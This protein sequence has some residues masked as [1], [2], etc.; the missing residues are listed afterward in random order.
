MTTA[1]T[2]QGDTWDILAFRLLGSEVFVDKLLQINPTLRDVAVFSAGQT[3]NV[4]DLPAQTDENLP[5]WRRTSGTNAGTLQ[6]AGNDGANEAA[7]REMQEAVEGLKGWISAGIQDEVKE[8]FAT[9]LVRSTGTVSQRS[10][11]DRFADVINVRDFGAK[12][13]GK[14]DDTDAIQAAFD[15]HVGGAAGGRIVFPRGTYV[16][17]DS[18]TLRNRNR[19]RTLGDDV[20]STQWAQ[21][22]LC[23]S[24][25]AWHG[26]DDASPVLIAMV[27][28]CTIMNGQ[29]LGAPKNRA[30]DTHRAEV[31]LKMLNGEAANEVCFA[32]RIHNMQLNGYT[33]AG[34]QIGDVDHMGSYG[35]QVSDCYITA[36]YSTFSAELFDTAKSATQPG[37]SGPDWESNGPAGIELWGA[38]C[39]FVNVTTQ[40]NKRHVWLHTSGHQFTNCHFCSTALINHNDASQIAS[41]ADYIAYAAEHEINYANSAGMPETAGIWY[42]LKDLINDPPLYDKTTKWYQ[43]TFIGCYFDNVK[44]IVYNDVSHSIQTQLNGCFYF[45]ASSVVPANPADPRTY[46]LGGPADTGSVVHVTNFSIQPGTKTRFLSGIEPSVNYS[47]YCRE[48]YVRNTYANNQISIPWLAQYK[49]PSGRAVQLGRVSE[50]AAGTA[51]CLGGV[52]VRDLGNAVFT[53]KITSQNYT[54]FEA[55]IR[56]RSSNPDKFDVDLKPGFSTQAFP[57]VTLHEPIDV[58]V[59]GTALK[60][61]PIC[62]WND[63]SSAITREVSATLECVNNRCGLYLMSLSVRSSLADLETRGVVIKTDLR[64]DANTPSG[65]ARLVTLRAVGG[66]WETLQLRANCD[67]ASPETNLASF[68]ST[69]SYPVRCEAGADSDAPFSGYG[70]LEVYALPSY[71]YVSSN[72]VVIQKL[73]SADVA[74]HPLPVTYIRTICGSNQSIVG[75]WREVAMVAAGS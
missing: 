27:N 68:L 48:D 34:L 60:F 3:I 55:D 56:Y 69:G 63:G 15:E 46:L 41:L 12:G 54:S 37:Y 62:L 16:V 10:L 14:T 38:D 21:L 65:S 17:T 59:R 29:I 4:P 7:R 53:L 42:S 13:D 5:L 70:L 20:Y 57:K 39:K 6:A 52:L 74:T 47:Y 75:E 72:P 35:T 22:D 51:Y 11:N 66:L 32:A 58:D 45:N 23:G 40:R 33:R 67:G 36:N 43:N 19:R 8:A 18:V 28:N 26:D 71:G 61:V 9:A 73:T 49:V 31:C 2:Q 64:T 24:C 1:T 44:Y 30:G 25:L 50:L